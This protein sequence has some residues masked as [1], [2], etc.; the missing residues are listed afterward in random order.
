MDAQAANN[1]AVELMRKHGLFAN[2]WA[3]RFDRATRRCGKCRYGSRL[4]QL[5]KP[6]VLVNNENEVRETILHEIAHALTPGANHGPV[7]KLKAQEIGASPKSCADSS[8]AVAPKG[9]YEGYCTDCGMT[10]Y[11]CRKPSR[12]YYHTRCRRRFCRNDGL[13]KWGKPPVPVDIEQ[14]VQP[15]VSQS[16]VNAILPAHEPKIG[17][18][19]T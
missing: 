17:E 16:E 10:V 11:K 14:T 15:T 7:W 18:L 8:T 12:P 5:S 13:I 3:F 9:K 2:G 4:I 1:L 19:S 6:F